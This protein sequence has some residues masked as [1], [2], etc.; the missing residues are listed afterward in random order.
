M[1]DFLEGFEI[2]FNGVLVAI[3]ADELNL[4]NS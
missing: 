2:S 1:M 3:L 4:T